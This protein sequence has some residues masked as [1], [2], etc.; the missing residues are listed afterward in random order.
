VQQV[1]SDRREAGGHA[2]RI[3]LRRTGG[4]LPHFV[5]ERL[6]LE[7]AEPVSQLF[8]LLADDVAHQRALGDRDRL[9]AEEL[10][11]VDR[12]EQAGEADGGAALP[13][14]QLA[15]DALEV[16]DQ[17]GPAVAHV[18]AGIG[19]QERERVRCGG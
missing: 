9:A 3:A 5:D 6:G 14:L 4:E 7:R 8:R 1:Q 2:A 17:G 11:A 18:D 13:L 15:P 12:M 10:G 19:S 16:R